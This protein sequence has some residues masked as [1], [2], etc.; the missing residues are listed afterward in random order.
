MSSNQQAYLPTPAAARYCARGQPSPPQPTISTDVLDRFSWPA[1]NQSSLGTMLWTSDECNLQPSVPCTPSSG[2]RSCRLY[3][4][5]SSLVRAALP[6]SGVRGV[7]LWCSSTD[8]ARLWCHTKYI[9]IVFIHQ[10]LPQFPSKINPDV[11][12]KV[13]KY[14]VFFDKLWCT[15]VSLHSDYS[16]TMWP[17]S[18]NFYFD[19]SLC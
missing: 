13:L 15:N 10:S 4:M 5:M 2:R 1:D 6:V 8:A 9:C 17:L 19:F 18:L 11:F 3:R 16:C 12:F 14:F 7:T